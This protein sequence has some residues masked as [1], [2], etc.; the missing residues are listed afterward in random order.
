[1]HSIGGVTVEEDAELLD[2]KVL[3]A[4]GSLMPKYA[5]DGSSGA[6]LCAAIDVTIDPGKWFLVRTGLKVELPAGYE[7]QIRP[8]SGL[9][10]K[11]GI[12][13]LNTPGTIDSDYRGEIGVILM[14]LGSEPFVV[15]Q[16]MKIAQMVLSRVAQANFVR[17]MGELEKTVRG[18]G[19]FGH[20]GT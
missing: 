2:V 6:D 16:G 19:G 13:V 11:H 12:M 9:A 20:T 17:V 10:L 18:E 3:A 7:F 5:T 8:R 4:D 1:M 15:E 14:N